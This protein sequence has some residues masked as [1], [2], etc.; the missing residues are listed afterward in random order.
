MKKGVRA[1]HQMRSGFLKMFTEK[2]LPLSTKL[3][4]S[5]RIREVPEEDKERVAKEIMGEYQYTGYLTL[6]AN[7]DSDP[8]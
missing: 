5:E 4:L 6:T 1:T 3:A 8:D 7:G 2:A